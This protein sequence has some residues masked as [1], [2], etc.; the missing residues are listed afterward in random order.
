MSGRTAGIKACVMGHPIAHSR[1]PLLHG[2]WLKTLGIAGTYEPADVAPAA[3]PEFLRGLRARGF[4]GGN[5]TVPHK[6]AAFRTVA[7]RDDDAEAIGAVNTVWY[8]GDQLVGGNTDAY[9]FLAHLDATVPGWD[10]SAHAALV[11]GAG[12]AARAIV[13]ALLSRVAA[14]HLVNRTPAR[15]QEL[16]AHFGPAVSAHGFAD[17]PALLPAADLLVNAT[18]LGMAGHPAI[19]LD[20][21]AFMGALKPGAAVYDIVYVPFETALLKAAKAHGHPAV[22]GLGMLMHQAVPGFARWFGVTP[23][24]TAEL[25]ALLEADIRKE[26]A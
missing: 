14:V 18:S 22:D 15:A 4:V 10:A 1:S 7:R 9:G 12:G 19:A 21:D 26:S 13:Y 17:L 8:E 5:V 16:A 20:M 24:V 11:L 2:H 25:R 23:T 3:F 6:E